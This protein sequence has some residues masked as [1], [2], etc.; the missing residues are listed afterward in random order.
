MSQ[1]GSWNIPNHFPY[2]DYSQFNNGYILARKHDNKEKEGIKELIGLK[3]NLIL[4]TLG[5]YALHVE[6]LVPKYQYHN[7]TNPKTE[8]IE[9]NK[10]FSSI[11]SAIDMLLWA[12][13]KVSA[14]VC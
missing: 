11:F 9:E 12:M 5:L 7:N 3:D 10:K 13:L 8:Q 4:E 1:N 14:F 2:Y 6:S